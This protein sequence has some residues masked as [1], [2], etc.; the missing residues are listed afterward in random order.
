MVGLLFLFVA[1]L[2]CCVD[3][4]VGLGCYAVFA[5]FT[6]LWVIVCLGILIACVD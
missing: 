3:L 5:C 2:C 1:C 4:F 6:V